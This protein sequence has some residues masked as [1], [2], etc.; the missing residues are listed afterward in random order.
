MTKTAERP[1]LASTYTPPDTH[2]S[3]PRNAGAETAA[4]SGVVRR[5][6]ESF[7]LI[8]FRLYRAIFLNN[9]R[10]LAGGKNDNRL[11]TRWGHVFRQLGFGWRDTCSMAG[12]CRAR[13]QGDNGDVGEEFRRLLVAVVIGVV[14]AVVWTWRTGS[15]ARAMGQ[16]G[17]PTALH[18]SRSR[19]G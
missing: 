12:R 8:A 1:A 4:P 7:A 11:A 13:T 15:A 9:Y 19:L 10:S 16:R 5:A 18:A 17:A 14:G 2:R 6:L 3:G